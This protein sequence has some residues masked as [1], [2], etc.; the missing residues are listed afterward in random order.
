M[1]IK[2]YVA[3]VF[4]NKTFSGAQ[5]A[6]IPQAENLSNQLMQCI[7]QELNLS[8]TAFVFPA[9]S[10]EHT[11]RVRIYTPTRE[12]DFAGQVIMAVAHVLGAI[13]KINLTAAEIPLTI[14]LNKQLVS[15]YITADNGM[16]VYMGFSMQVSPIVDRF[17][18]LNEELAE[19]LSLPVAAIE[20]KPMSA[21]LVS[22][23]N[24]YL[25]VPLRSE[26]AVW[27][28]R[29]NLSSWSASHAPQ[30]AAQELL[31]VTSHTEQNKVDFNARL[32]GPA[33]G[34]L[35]DPPVGAAMPAFAAYLASHEHVRLG[36]YAFSVERGTKNTRQSLL[37]VEMDHKGSDILAVRI[38]GEAVMVSEGV[39]HV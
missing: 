37:T 34:Q 18:P 17:A 11:C 19:I 22:T 30:T 14:E 12:I 15:G 33:I 38:G 6:V 2:F 32:V 24:P 35:E 29:F 7:A 39:M 23:G 13:G 20:Y 26:A 25:I 8:Q 16:P 9:D 10:T 27:Q 4:T 5:I 21:R 36:R 31:L 28:A 1:D 3:N